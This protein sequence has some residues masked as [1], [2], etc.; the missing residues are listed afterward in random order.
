LYRIFTDKDVPWDHT[1]AFCLG[2]FTLDNGL[3]VIMLPMPASPQ[4][5]DMVWYKV[6]SADD[7]ADRASLAHL[8]EQV[9]FR[10]VGAHPEQ[11]AAQ[12]EVHH[13][14]SLEGK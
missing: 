11:D 7:P 12:I 2:T 14:A 13:S 5:T 8:M 9:A 10:D 6:G 4:V 3:Q 1:G